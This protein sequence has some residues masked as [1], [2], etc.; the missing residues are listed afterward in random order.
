MVDR[1]AS[2]LKHVIT[3]GATSAARAARHLDVLGG[4]QAARLQPVELG[5]VVEHHG[6]R[7]HVHAH[8]ERLRREQDLHLRTDSLLSP[9]GYCCSVTG[10]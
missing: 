3:S 10:S 8:R 6:A 2:S 9:L 5:D 1:A 4:R 7:R